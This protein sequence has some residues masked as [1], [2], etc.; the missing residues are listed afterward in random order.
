MLEQQLRACMDAPVRSCIFVR[1]LKEVEEQD[2]KQQVLQWDRLLMCYWDMQKEKA[3]KRNTINYHLMRL[4][5]KIR[6]P[7]KRDK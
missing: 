6:G 3:P 1:L 7:Y 5:P 2:E 4:Y